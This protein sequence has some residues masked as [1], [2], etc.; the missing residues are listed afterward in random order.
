MSKYQIDVW[1]DGYRWIALL[2]GEYQFCAATRDEAFALAYN[3]KCRMVG[4]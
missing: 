3:A 1:H 4:M 2:G